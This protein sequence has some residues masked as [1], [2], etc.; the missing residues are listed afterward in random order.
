M[1]FE[2]TLKLASDLAETAEFSNKYFLPKPQSPIEALVKT[3]D[4]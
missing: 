1:L 3:M 2:N 4:I